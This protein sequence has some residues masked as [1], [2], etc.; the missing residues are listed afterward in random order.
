MVPL[1]VAH[2]V[3]IVDPQE[4]AV[5][6]LAHRRAQ[7]VAEHRPRPV[8]QRLPP[9]GPSPGEVHILEPGRIEPGIEAA[10]GLEALAAQRQSRGG[11]LRDRRSRRR[12]FSSSQAAAQEQALEQQI[13]RAGQAAQLPA[14]LGRVVQPHQPR[15]KPGRLRV[16]FE[17]FEQLLER[18]C[19]G[20]HVRVEQEQQRRS[21]PRHS[22]VHPRSEAEVGPGL[23]AQILP[24]GQGSARTVVHHHQLETRIPGPGR[25]QLLQPGL[26]VPVHHHPGQLGLALAGGFLHGRPRA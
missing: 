25:H 3:A 24:C 20:F 26:V 15:R 22:E 8:E 23:E 7:A 6:E 4:R 17:A 19:L 14:E 9:V 1:E 13:P 2:Q 16:R 10:Q 18:P 11:R 12:L 5:A 21:G